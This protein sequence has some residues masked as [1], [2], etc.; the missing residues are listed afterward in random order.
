MVQTWFD[1]L[2]WIEANKD[3]AIAIMAKKAGVSAADYKTYDAGT[4]IFTREQN[5]AAFTA[6]HAPRPTSTTRPNQI[7]EFLVE[8]RAGRRAS[9]R[10]TGCSS[11]S[12]CKAVVDVIDAGRH[13]RPTRPGAGRPRGGRRCRGAGRPRRRP[14]LLAI[15][16]PIPRR[17]R[18]ALIAL[19]VL[20][21]AR[22]SGGCS[23]PAG[24]VPARLPAHARRDVWP[25]GLEMAASRAAARRHLGHA[26][27]GCCS[28]SG[29]PS[30]VS[31]PLGILDGQLPAGA[32]RCS[33]R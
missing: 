10:W 8:H 20:V 6:G 11:P 4:T 14:A 32:G 17:T 26:C 24:V 28:G 21:P 31:V 27:S 22:A 7:A 23:A 16:A 15:R 25:A 19:S 18:L 3:A 13:G 12:S 9:R 29:W 1:T 2:A 33:S 30:L 5:L